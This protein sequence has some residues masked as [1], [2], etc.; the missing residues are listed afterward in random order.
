MGTRHIP[1]ESG[2]SEVCG[3]NVSP[4]AETML[5]AESLQSTVIVDALLLMAETKSAS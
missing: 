5:T 1:P 3:K 4:F 2:E